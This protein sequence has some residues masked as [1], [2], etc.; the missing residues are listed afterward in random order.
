MGYFPTGPRAG[1]H[2]FAAAKDEARVAAETRLGAQNQAWDAEAVQC[3]TQAETVVKL[4]KLQPAP[5][6]TTSKHLSKT[7]AAIP[8]RNSKVASSGTTKGSALL[9]NAV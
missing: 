3:K 4:S 7:S 5:S 8:K 6:S 9:N 1:H 2:V